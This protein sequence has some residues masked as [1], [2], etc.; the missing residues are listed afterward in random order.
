[1]G[2]LLTGRV[3]DRCMPGTTHVGPARYRVTVS[4]NCRAKTR[5]CDDPAMPWLL[6]NPAARIASPQNIIV[7]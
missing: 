6:G 4:T 1:M 2:A 5:C 3:I 7:R